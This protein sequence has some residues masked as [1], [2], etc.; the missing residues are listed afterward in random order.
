[1]TLVRHRIRQVL[2]SGYLM[3]LGT[4]D[5]GGPW[6]SEVLYVCAE[7][8]NIYWMSSPRSR[9]SLAVRAL[10]Q[11]AASIT[12]SRRAGEKDLGV[13]LSGTA[14]CQGKRIPISIMTAY[15]AKYRITRAR[16]TATLKTG[17]DWYVLRPTFIELIDQANLGLTK[18]RLDLKADSGTSTFETSGDQARD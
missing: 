16:V 3:S 5:P 1:M 11:V 18:Q 14:M 10:G 13:Q 9:H 7:G 12:I 17:Y 8:W 4:T 6:V 15:L 2:D